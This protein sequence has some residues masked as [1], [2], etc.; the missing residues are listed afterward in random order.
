MGSCTRSF[1]VGKKNLLHFAAAVCHSLSQYSDV[2]NCSRESW[3]QDLHVLH[4]GQVVF[5]G[6]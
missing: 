6:K 2:C 4:E 3:Q 5:F 1:T